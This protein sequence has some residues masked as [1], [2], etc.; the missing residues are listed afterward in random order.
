MT[1]QSAL[2]GVSEAT[3]LLVEPFSDFGGLVHT[4]LDMRMLQWL[5]PKGSAT[6]AN[7]GANF[8]SGSM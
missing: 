6:C 4:G 8:K 2:V 1:R 3:T 5:V 7:F